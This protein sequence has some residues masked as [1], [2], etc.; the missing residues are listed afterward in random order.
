MR[1]AWLALA[2][3]AV[4]AAIFHNLLPVVSTHIYSDTGDPLLNASIL[5]WNAE[6]VPLTAAWWNYPAFAPLSG[7]TAWTEH[8]LGAYPLTTP[9]VWATG[10]A[11]LAYNVLLLMCFPLNALAMFA[12]AREVTG[13]DAGAFVAG[14]AFA[15]APYQSEQI[16]HVQ[17]LMAFGMPLAL[18]GL[19]EQVEHGRRRGIAWFAVGWLSAILSNAYMLVFFPLLIA[20]WCVWF[21][22]PYSSS[23]PAV[24]RLVP[25]AV[26]VIATM[27]TVAP[28][29]WGYHVRQAAYGLERGYIDVKTFSADIAGL[30][31]ISHRQPLWR[32]VLNS[33]LGEA[34]I[35]PGFAVLALTVVGLCVHL[36][37]APGRRKVARYFFA[38][39]AMC[40]AVALA[41]SFVG[42][43]GWHVG[44]LTLPPFRPFRVFTF[45]AVLFII[46]VLVTNRFRNAWA[47]RDAVVFYV[48]A[49]VMMWLFAIGPEPSWSGVRVLTYGPYWLLMHLPGGGS[50]RV[51]AR[52]WLL[53]VACLAMTAGA[54]AA[55]L[56][57]RARLRWLAIALAG[58]VVAEGWFG[59]VAAEIPPGVWA[60]AIP[61]G[62]IVLDLPIGATAE[63]V[64]PEYL[65]V[66]GG[67]RAVNGYSGYAPPHFARLREALASHQAGT[68]DAFRQYQDLY[69]IIRPAVDTAFLRWLEEQD[70]AELISTGAAWRLYRLPLL[71]EHPF[72]SLP[73]G[74]PVPGAL[75]FQIP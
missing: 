35:F 40:L 57:R 13:S 74:L 18:L 12:L 37:C 69:V 42:P 52:A 8:L 28:L 67:Y 61:H 64:P 51:A 20:L 48:T 16:S 21:I 75:P 29:L 36:R 39:A 62:A 30:A 34:S 53:A 70:G 32:G 11:L 26:A 72:V 22:R 46:G 73:F 27:V 45:G 19:H 25:I 47:Q 5:A 10:N 38:A 7:V 68:F 63:N 41:R 9:I 49:A 4:T 55:W 54:G 65:A 31:G 3:V 59:D 14:L 1:Y 15:F 66:V 6:H 50:I 56:L 24:R 44:P 71:A 23:S 33:T 58:I 43:S 17:M 60:G 2:Y